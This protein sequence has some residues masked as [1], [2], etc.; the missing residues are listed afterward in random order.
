MPYRVA[1][2]AEFREGSGWH[3]MGGG[4]VVFTLGAVDLGGG[5]IMRSGLFAV[6]NQE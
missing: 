4:C 6:G 3:R 2:R 5:N 1:E